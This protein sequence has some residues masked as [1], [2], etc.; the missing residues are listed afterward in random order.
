MQETEKVSNEES[1]RYK[2]RRYNVQ[3]GLGLRKQ[4]ILT[5]R[6]KIA[7]DFN[8]DA[9]M[10]H[11][12][13]LSS[14]CDR[15]LS[16]EVLKD[17]LVMAPVDTLDEDEPADDEWAVTSNWYFC[18]IEEVNMDRTVKVKVLGT[19]IE[20]VDE[21]LP[22]G[23]SAKVQTGETLDNLGEVKRISMY[24]IPDLDGIPRPWSMKAEGI[25]RMLKVGGLI[26][27]LGGR[28]DRLVKD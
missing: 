5:S 18:Y 19:V 14:S 1:V 25:K 28:F 15:M 24:G 20:T 23:W 26:R 13:W 7:S 12:K 16:S 6:L 9:P 10:E 11:S 4:K 27:L 3:H 2:R 21:H 22:I 8:D 17:S